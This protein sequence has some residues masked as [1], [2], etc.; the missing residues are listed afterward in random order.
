VGK[1]AAAATCSPPSFAA[2][3][4]DLEGEEQLEA[5]EASIAAINPTARRLRTHRCEVDVGA[6]L[7]LRALAGDRCSCLCAVLIP[8]AF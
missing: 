3:Q 8:Y 6:I 7:D 2:L 5:V 4:V 1:G